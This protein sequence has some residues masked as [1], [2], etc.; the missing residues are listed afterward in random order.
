MR[1]D[2]TGLRDAEDAA[3]RR[4]LEG[5]AAETGEGFFAALVQ[6][7][8]HA[9]GAS[10]AWVTEYLEDARRLRALAFWLDGKLVEHYEYDIDG[11][12]CGPVIEQRRLLHVADKVVDL[13]PGDPDMRAVGAVSYLGVPFLD[14]DGTV[15]GHLAVLDTKPMPEEPRTM[16]LFRIFAARAAAELRRL[17]A[18]AALREREEQLSRLVEGAMDAIVELDQALNV[19]RLNPA[20]GRMFGRPDAAGAPFAHLLQQ[21]SRV[22]LT[23]LVADLDAS[24]PGRQS[25]WISG[26]LEAR[27][28]DGRRFRVEA[29]LSRFEARRRVFYVLILRDVE[30]RL[31]A[32]RR[33]QSLSQEASYLREEL[34]AL[35]NCDDIMGRSEALTRVLAEVQQVAATDST[36]LV[37]GE[38]G[39]GKELIARAL[40]NA[41]GRRERTLVTLNCAAIPRELIES[42]L[43]GHEKGAFTGAT[44]KRPGR[45]ALADRATLFLDEVGELPLD[46]QAKLLR[47]LQE[48]EFEP[49]GSHRTQ[50]VDVRIVAATNRDLEAAVAAGEFREDLFYRLNVFPIRV[51]PLRE[52]GGDV[53]LL[54][55]AFLERFAK[56]MGKPF[57]PLSPDCI[58][59]LMGY[60]WPGNVRELEN[61]IERAAILSRDG[62]LDLA[63]AL[64]EAA[65]MSRTTPVPAS[66][67]GTVRTA[68]EMQALERDNLLRALEACNWKVS[69]SRGAARMLGMKPTTLSS[70]LK[71]MGIERPR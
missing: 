26:G 47:V 21:E 13:F 69:G 59:R 14:D 70:R 44:Q 37:M 3:L 46:L 50:R 1:R 6:N 12:P 57:E 40:H 10:G 23:Q 8:A 20:A 65:P 36:V 11:T 17:R 53:V 62:R 45:F 32:E 2:E 30:E 24:P 41:S 16:A 25:L 67:V 33:I 55:R 42:E 31:A 38:T 7:L 56:R 68:A 60:H 43:F 52:R 58:E 49:L 39:T 19:R 22:R 64:P 18:T 29:T 71:A 63:R 28:T 51:P 54:A 48:G 27:R 5:T 9:M 4:V 35:H 61:V 34:R 15:L 66:G